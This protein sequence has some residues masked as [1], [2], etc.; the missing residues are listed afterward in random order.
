MKT[1][2][3][4]ICGNTDPAAIEKIK[5]LLVTN[6]IDGVDFHFSEDPIS[7]I[8]TVDS[9]T[10][11]M[12]DKEIES[13]LIPM[14]EDNGM[15]LILPANTKHF[16]F[17]DDEKRKEPRKV[18]L[19]TLIIAVTVTLVISVLFT[20]V[21][22]SGL[23]S[24]PNLNAPQSADVI[25]ISDS[26][27]QVETLNKIFAE[28]QIDYKNLDPEKL[29]DALLKAY[30]EATGDKYAIYYNAEEYAN[31]LEEQKG[32]SAGIG[33]VVS[34]STI[35]VNNENITVIEIL[36]VNT[37]SAAMQAG[38]KAGDCIYA[39]GKGQSRVLV[40]SVGYDEA[41]DLLLG[42]I[43]TNA[44]ISI[45]RK[46]DNGE[47]VSMDFSITRATYESDTVLSNICATNSKVGIVKLLSFGLKTPKQF[48]QAVDSLKAQGCEYFIFD[49][50]SNPGG[51]LN[52]IKAILSYFLD[53]GDLI[54]SV[55]YSDGT[56]KEN[57]VATSEYKEDSSYYDCSVSKEDIGKYKDLEFNILT[58][59]NTAS[60]AELFT[61]TVRDYNL[62]KII[63]E[64]RT[65]GKG[66]MQSIIPLSSYGLQGGLRVTTAMYFSKSHTVYHDIGIIPDIVEPLNDEAKK[67]S[68]YNL[69]CELDNQL[70]KAINEL[71]K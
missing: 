21:F 35:S 13:I 63:G 64:E 67:Y 19:R 26:T 51:D 16:S 70:Q 57:T 50:R 14:L 10:V 6:K 23:L 17:I 31:W 24:I 55:E 43:G 9:K 34:K 12:T 65:F 61:A 45:Y 4:L 52:S 40:D 47:Y 60:A 68:I 66:C 59:K 28:L 33:V 3:Y 58:D 48:S 56:V 15:S 2:S 39:V 29:T 11:S 46:S 18:S 7:I 54:L 38:L 37:Q 42:E 44:D 5:D 49:L 25:D 62:G 69:P 8:A 36:Y 41:T 27:K 30:V 20:Y 71:I 53:E 1:Y 22:A 32:T